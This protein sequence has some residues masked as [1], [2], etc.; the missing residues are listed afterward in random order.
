MLGAQKDTRDRSAIQPRG[1]SIPAGGAVISRQHERQGMMDLTGAQCGPFH[2]WGPI[3][4]GG[5]SHVWLARHRELSVPVILKTMR[6]LGA[7]GDAF[8]HCAARSRR[9][10]A[11]PNSFPQVFREPAPELSE[12]L[13]N[14]IDSTHRRG[15]VPLR[16]PAARGSS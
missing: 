6:E 14:C 7:R 8:A 2:V 9:R 10:A 16:L 5:M 12:W 3:T 15:P 4:E 13:Y 11:F 1:R